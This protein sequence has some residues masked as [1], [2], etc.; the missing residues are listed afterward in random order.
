MRA[1]LTFAVLVMFS[2][3]YA[4]DSPPGFFD[5]PWGTSIDSTRL[6]SGG[7]GW[8][9]D[10]SAAE[11]PP[12]LNIQV[13]R[14]NNTIAGYNATVRYYFYESR[15]FQTTVMFDF[16]K[17]TS[18]DFNYNVYRSV[19]EYYTYIRSNT[20]SFVLDVYDLLSKKYGKK[21]PVFKGLDPRYTFVRLDALVK[22]ERWNF[23][24][25]PFD[26]YQMIVTSSYALW[27]FPHTRVI[28][29]INISAPDK[30]FEYTL[31]AASLDMVQ[32]VTIRRDKLR[33]SGL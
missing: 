23:R 29:S 10:G 6:L 12:E 25:H 28:F 26:F 4:S 20:L 8:G 15:L 30:R 1:S 7:A 18:Y 2:I 13:Y 9:A 33:M 14:T 11:F 3:V 17:L 19:T 32:M 22:Q 21:E 31:S 16:A 5:V 24:Y 27:D